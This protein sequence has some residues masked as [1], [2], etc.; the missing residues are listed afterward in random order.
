MPHNSQIKPAKNQLAL[1]T[2]VSILSMS[3]ITGCQSTTAI[4]TA[5]TAPMITDTQSPSRLQAFN[6]RGK[7]GV[8]TPQ[9]AD[10]SRQAGSA[11]YVWAQDDE[12]FAIDLT[13]ALGVGHTV[14]EYNGQ[15]ATLV[16]ERTGTMTAANPEDLLQQAT[17]WQAPISQ[18]PYWIS[19]SPAPSDTDIIFDETNHLINAT[20]GDWVASFDYAD[21]Q[22]TD[23]NLRKL[24]TRIEVQKQDGH[25]V[26]MTINHDSSES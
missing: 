7:I 17:G 19:G 18:L 22:P 14:I 25:K 26:I 5:T 11:F 8:I 4:G 10:K 20:N 1:L 12:R 9:N 16:S 21:T 24:P 6:I 2:L 15:T 23:T 13:G 3:V